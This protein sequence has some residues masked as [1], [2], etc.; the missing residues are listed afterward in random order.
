MFGIAKSRQPLPHRQRKTCRNGYKRTR[1]PFPWPPCAS[2]K[3]EVYRLGFIS[4]TGELARRG[5]IVTPWHVTVPRATPPVWITLSRSVGCADEQLSEHGLLK[6]WQ[7]A[8]RDHER[9]SNYGKSF[10]Y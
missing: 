4:V 9:I 8:S 10:G 3:Q 6:T 7:I 5:A 2:L 1:Y